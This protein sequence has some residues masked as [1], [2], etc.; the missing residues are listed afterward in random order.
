M[1]PLGLTESSVDSQYVSPCAAKPHSAR[2]AHSL[3]L[4]GPILGSHPWIGG[5]TLYSD[6]P[7]YVFPISLHLRRSL[8]IPLSFLSSSPSRST[9]CPSRPLIHFLLLSV[10]ATLRG[11]Q[12]H[13]WVSILS[14]LSLAHLRLVE[15]LCSTRIVCIWARP[16]LASLRDQATVAHFPLPVSFACF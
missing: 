1:N 12:Y 6:G 15:Y 14:S 4:T 8:S 5:L 2:V 16:R 3:P 9:S 13:T 10:I 7:S 11:R